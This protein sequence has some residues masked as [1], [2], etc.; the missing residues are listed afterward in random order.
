[1]RLSVRYELDPVLVRAT[2]DPSR[3][4]PWPRNGV[5]P[6]SLASLLS[7]TG[8]LTTLSY[9]DE[10]DLARLHAHLRYAWIPAGSGALLFKDSVSEVDFHQK[11]LISDE[12]G[13][14]IGGLV[15][16]RMFGVRYFADA[17]PFLKRNPTLRGR[18]TPGR[19]KSPDFVGLD[20]AGNFFIIECKGTQSGD[21]A[22][23]GQIESGRKQKSIRLTGVAPTRMVI[24]TRFART[25]RSYDTLTRI[26][27]P[28]PEIHFT[29]DDRTTIIQEHYLKIASAAGIRV[30]R[31][32]PLSPEFALDSN[33]CRPVEVLGVHGLGSSLTFWAS[34]LI[35]EK[36]DE[37]QTLREYSFTVGIADHAL[38]ALRKKGTPSYHDKG[39]EESSNSKLQIFSSAG[40]DGWLV[41]IRP[42]EKGRANRTL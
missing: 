30:V 7:E 1:M 2:N 20:A 25:S 9:T 19:Q 14:G 12:L 13:V 32:T 8:K 6:F 16:S 3:G 40:A 24:A 10:F 27:D 28:V 41:D 18:R 37:G 38:T 21:A 5:L 17:Y 4:R 26:V 33:A 31:K 15:A 35:G 29:P 36:A 23:L 11:G 22:S 42:V 39:T 34:S